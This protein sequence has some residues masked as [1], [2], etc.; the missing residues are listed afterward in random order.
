MSKVVFILVVSSLCASLNLQSQI[1]LS[2]ASFEGTPQDATTPIGWTPCQVTSTP[3]ILPGFWGVQLPAQQG[4]SYVGLIA[5]EDGSNENIGQRLASPI[6]KGE[7]YIFNL[8]LARSNTYAGYKL[9]L[10]LR[11]W[12]GSSA[13]AKEQLLAE[14]NLIKH[15]DW[16]RYYF[17]FVAKK[18]YHYIIIEACY[19]TGVMFPYKGNILIDG[20]SNLNICPRASVGK[21]TKKRKAVPKGTAFSANTNYNYYLSLL[22]SNDT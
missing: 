16:R 12:G 15:T 11:V 7:C 8:S 22:A 18:Q 10:K 13:C 6:R 1:R 20:I 5:R 21:S 14:S 3:D 4:V 19:A 17:S 9:P 2:N